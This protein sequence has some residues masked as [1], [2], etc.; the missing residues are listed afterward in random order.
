M[1][2]RAVFSN[3]YLHR[4]TKEESAIL[5]HINREGRANAGFCGPGS[6][7]WGIQIFLMEQ[8]LEILCNHTGPSRLFVAQPNV[9]CI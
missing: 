6:Q 8:R 3:I 9:T 4:P 1:E 7:W 5:E 2:K